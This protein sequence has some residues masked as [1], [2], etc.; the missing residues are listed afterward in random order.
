MFRYPFHIG[1]VLKPDLTKE[2][3]RAETIKALQADK[4][5]TSRRKKSSILLR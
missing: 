4:D 5:S 2:K 1:L 3:K